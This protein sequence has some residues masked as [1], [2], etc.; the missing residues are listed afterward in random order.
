[1]LVAVGLNFGKL[2]RDSPGMTADFQ[3]T[4]AQAFFTAEIV[5]LR[6]RIAVHLWSAM[7][8]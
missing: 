5:Y 3:V 1:M 6:H 7:G 4:G 8:R 2:T